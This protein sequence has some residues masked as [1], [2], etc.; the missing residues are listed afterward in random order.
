MIANEQ[1]RLNNAGDALLDEPATG[2]TTK[3]AS[4]DYTGNL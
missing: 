2:L 1:L 4:C 3:L